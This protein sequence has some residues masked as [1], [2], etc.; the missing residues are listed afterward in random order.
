MNPTQDQPDVFQ[1]AMGINDAVSVLK[2]KEKFVP[3]AVNL[4]AQGDVW[5]RRAG[6]DFYL[7]QTGMV[8]GLST[9]RFEDGQ[10]FNIAQIGSYLYNLS[11]TFSYLVA[12][13][14]KLY[15]QSADTNYWDVTP[16]ASTGLIVPT[17]VAAPAAAAQTSNFTVLNGES[18]GFIGA[19]GEVTRL[20]C[21][22][23][24]GGW[25]L[26]GYGVSTSTVSITTD[27]VFTVA[28]GFSFRIV[29]YAGNT[30]A[31]SV[32]NDGFMIVTTV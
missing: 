12:S 14:V 26:A 29:D 30:W 15:I 31:F 27:M 19:S 21:D 3:F 22:L 7:L 8:L 4:H 2:L 28:S 6:R 23:D 25:W 17:A 20:N 13:G 5:D 1:G 9:V 32:T 11:T 18:F 16:N 24:V 10:A